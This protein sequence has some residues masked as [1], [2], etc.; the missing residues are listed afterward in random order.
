MVRDDAKIEDARETVRRALRAADNGNQ[1]GEDAVV[2]MAAAGEM[3]KAAKA[4]IDARN[5]LADTPTHRLSSD[6]P[7]FKAVTDTL[8]ALSAAISRAEGR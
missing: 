7:R 6:D 3:L 5:T 4:H 8:D 2:A 1:A